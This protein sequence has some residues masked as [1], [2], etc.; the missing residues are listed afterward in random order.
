MMFPTDYNFTNSI[1]S[2]ATATN[3]QHS[4]GRSFAFDFKTHRFIFKDGK[5]VEDTNDHTS[6]RNNRLNS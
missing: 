2:T 1:Q 3:A 4:V 6:D 5:N